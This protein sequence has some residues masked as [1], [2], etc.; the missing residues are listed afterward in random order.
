M[1]QQNFKYNDILNFLRY[2]RSMVADDDVQCGLDD[3][4]GFPISTETTKCMY[5]ACLFHIHS[6]CAYIYGPGDDELFCSF[7]CVV[8]HATMQGVHS[9]DAIKFLHESCRV[10]YVV[11]TKK[12]LDAAE[13][14]ECGAVD[15]EDRNQDDEDE[16]DAED[17]AE[18]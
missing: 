12:E 11:Y 6:A 1:S 17:Q 2:P 5:N 15:V 9:N 4:I 8:D 18:D 14:K 3:C 10:A 7:R 13:E 16:D